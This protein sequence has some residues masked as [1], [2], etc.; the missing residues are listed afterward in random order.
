MK[1]KEGAFS[2]IIVTLVLIVLTAFAG[3]SDVLTQS[4]IL[5][6]TQ[7]KMDR[8]ALNALNSGIDISLLRNEVLAMDEETYIGRGRNQ[9]ANGMLEQS[10]REQNQHY[11]KAPSLTRYED[12]IER[13]FRVEFN[14]MMGTN[15]TIKSIQ[16]KKVDAEVDLTDWRTGANGQT[17]PQIY[18]DVIVQV[19]VKVNSRFDI[20]HNENAVRSVTNAK[21]TDFQVVVNGR[22]QDGVRELLIPNSTRL[23]YN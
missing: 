10:G 23:M 15:E 17:T 2:I 3:F 22:S 1:E 7:Q 19:D 16:L 6:E 21:G 8:A 20:F 13:A 18:L 4:V 9:E 5:N 12:E 14:N 11:Q